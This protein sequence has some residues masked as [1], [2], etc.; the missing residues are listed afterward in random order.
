[1]VKHWAYAANAFIKTANRHEIEWTPGVVDLRARQVA[2]SAIEFQLRSSTPNFKTYLANRDSAGWKPIDGDRLRI[3]L[4]PGPNKLQ[5][6]TENLAGVLGPIA[7][8]S[9]ASSRP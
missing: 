3:E 4:R 7:T 6:R 8:V 1:M 2:P 5:V 9:V